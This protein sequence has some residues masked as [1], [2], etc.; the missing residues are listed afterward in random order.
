MRIWKLVR[1]QV[2][3]T[4]FFSFSFHCEPKAKNRNKRGKEEVLGEEEEEE[5]EKM[6]EILSKRGSLRLSFGASPWINQ[7][8]GKGFD[9]LHLIIVRV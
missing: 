2:I 7:T 8:R 6:R 5:E 3:K 9:F 1:K 4:I